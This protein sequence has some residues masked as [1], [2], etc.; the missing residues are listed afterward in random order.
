MFNFRL[1]ILS[2][3]NPWFPKFQIEHFLSSSLSPKAIILHDFSFHHRLNLSSNFQ[4]ITGELT[5]HFPIQKKKAWVKGV[6]HNQY[7]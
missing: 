5:F 3:Q 6:A 2:F 7:T 4:D 1:T